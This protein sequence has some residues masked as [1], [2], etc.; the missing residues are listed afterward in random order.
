M[1]FV[2]FFKT[3]LGTL[4]LGK[5]LLM[6]QLNSQRAVG[7]CRLGLALLFLVV[8]LGLSLTV[9][10][11]SMLS[12]NLLLLTGS[13]SFKSFSRISLKILN[14]SLRASKAVRGL[15]LMLNLLMHVVFLNSLLS[16]D[17]EVMAFG[18]S[19]NLGKCIVPPLFDGVRCF[20]GFLKKKSASLLICC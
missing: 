6:L 8:I 7:G 3:F 17:L 18:K 9:Y 10:L 19:T 20:I 14:H 12:V 2:P 11:G 5:L 16:R 1:V 4:F 13:S 15:L